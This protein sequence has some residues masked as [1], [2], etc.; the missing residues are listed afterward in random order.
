[1]KRKEERCKEEVDDD[2][3]YDGDDTNLDNDG[4]DGTDFF[5]PMSSKIGSIGDDDDDDDVVI[6]FER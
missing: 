3:D 4:D 1:M 5:Y 2:N 6:L